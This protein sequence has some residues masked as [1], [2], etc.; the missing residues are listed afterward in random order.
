MMLLQ[1]EWIFFQHINH[2]LK[3]LFFPLD[4]EYRE[5][6]FLTLLGGRKEEVAISLCKHTTW[7]MKLEVIG[8]P[9]STHTATA[10]FDIMKHFCEILTVYL[11]NR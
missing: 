8:I 3:N 5:N 6:F 2:L 4:A 9:D 10:N 7:G 1:K 11:L